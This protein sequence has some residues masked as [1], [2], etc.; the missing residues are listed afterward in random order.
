MKDVKF[1]MEFDAFELCSPE[2]QKKL[3]P[4]RDKFKE[5]EDKKVEE[6]QKLTDKK[7]K[8]DEPEKAVKTLPFW[9]EDGIHHF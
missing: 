9:F 3:I 7:P 4:M 1:P 8:V 2:L 5:L 6:A